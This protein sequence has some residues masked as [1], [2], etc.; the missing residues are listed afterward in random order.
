MAASIAAILNIFKSL[1]LADFGAEFGKILRRNKGHAKN[2]QPR[3]THLQCKLCSTIW[4]TCQSHVY[5]PKTA[6]EI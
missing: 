2:T 5:E 1:L 4:C 3:E 6:N